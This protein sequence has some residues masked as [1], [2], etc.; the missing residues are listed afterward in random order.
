M[1][2]IFICAGEST[3][4]GEHLGIS[5]HFA[6]IGG[7]PILERAIRL[8]KANGVKDIIVVS[9]SYELEGVKN[10][11]PILTPE[12][13]DADK[14]LSSHQYW[15]DND[16]TLIVYGDV[17][18]TEDAVR[19]VVEDD[20]KDFRLFCRPTPSKVTGTE[21]GE[22]FAFSL[23]PDDLKE[24]REALCY[25]VWLY[26]QEIL[27][28]VGGWEWVRAMYVVKAGRMS[29]HLDECPLYMVIDD[30]TDDIDYPDDHTRIQE[31]W[32]RANA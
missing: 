28:R 24:A 15:H 23:Y 14:F 12:Y 25:L 27:E 3:R 20:S 10:I 5:K 7:E 9:K 2:A 1:R 4:W 31:A 19:T 11:Y 6:P 17:Y 16:R 22:C 18:W 26:E 30:M 13:Y 32:D 29:E 8:F 21:W